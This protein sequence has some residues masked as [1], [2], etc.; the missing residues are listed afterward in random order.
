VALSLVLVLGT[1]YALRLPQSQDRDD[2][3]AHVAGRDSLRPDANLDAKRD[4]G[5]DGILGRWQEQELGLCLSAYDQ[6]GR[7]IRSE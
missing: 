3:P 7:A 6:F 4:L 2:F 1:Y 5:E